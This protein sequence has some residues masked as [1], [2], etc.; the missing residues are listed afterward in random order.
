MRHA[1]TRVA[2]DTY[3]QAISHGSMIASRSGNARKVESGAVRIDSRS[4][5]KKAP[6]QERGAR[7]CV[8]FCCAAQGIG[9][10]LCYESVFQQAPRPWQCGGIHTA[11]PCAGRVYSIDKLAKRGKLSPPGR[12]CRVCFKY[13]AD[14]IPNC[15]S[16]SFLS[17]TNKILLFSRKR[18]L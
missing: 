11:I 15:S 7:E 10:R 4:L 14:G 1:S 8:A 18:D 6:K 2:L 17:R 9:C 3:T 16:R 13:G 12:A 5:L